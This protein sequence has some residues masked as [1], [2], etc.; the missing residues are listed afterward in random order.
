MRPG[1]RVTLITES[2]RLLESRSWPEL[3]VILRQFRTRTTDDFEGQQ[4][5]YALEMLEGS[6]DADLRELHAFLT[7]Q[8]EDD[9]DALPDPQVWTIGQLRLFV[10]HLAEYAEYV[11]EI[12]SYLDRDGVSGFVSHKHRTVERV[13][14][15]NKGSIAVM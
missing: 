15:R 11:G 4:Y 1:E 2:A 5:H 3:D 14:G 12:G 9:A 10:S 8:D 6:K 13:G 7:G